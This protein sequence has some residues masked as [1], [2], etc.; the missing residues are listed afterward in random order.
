MK[1]TTPITTDHQ[2][3]LEGL[4]VLRLIADRLEM[5]EFVEPEDI[6]CVLGFLRDV[7]CE[8]LSKTEQLLLQPALSRATQKGLVERLQKA[9]AC[10]AVVSPL[11]E[12]LVS[13]VNFSKYFILH[14]HLFTKL[15]GDLI[16]EEDHHLIDAAL[17][18]LQDR[19]GQSSVANFIA[20][21]R[22]ISGLAVDGI[23]T[24]HRLET[25]YGY[26]HCV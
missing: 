25:K 22:H 3:I 12:D 10:H 5:D 17:D 8:C 6:T 1:R 4:E 14:A 19:E 15:V 18:L 24:L 11:F 2:L 9:L 21:E 20:Q 26:P 7:G 23:S 13:D 16:F